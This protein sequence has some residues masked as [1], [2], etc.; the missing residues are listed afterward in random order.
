VSPEPVESKR[1]QSRSVEW[2]V[3]GGIVFVVL[4]IVAAYV[5]ERRR[6]PAARFPVIAQ[7]ADFALTNQLAQ[8]V[9][10]ADLRG[11]VWVADIIFTRCPGPCAT[12]TRRMAD[13]Q[14]ALP[15]NAPVKLVSLTTDPAHDTP[16]A[17][18]SYA[19]RFGADSN[20]WQFLTG[21]KADLVKL[22]VN[23]LKLTVLDKE[24]AKRTSPNDL[25]I[26]SSIFVVVDKQGRLRAVF[27]SLDN[28]LAE[29]EVATGASQAGS[30]WEKTGKPRLL[31]AVNALLVEPD[32]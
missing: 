2:A 22:A 6:V 15:A 20:R 32:R 17:L 14:A 18:A 30:T 29:E 10:L 21:P 31:E 12:M 11:Q 28:V 23:S 27:E 4:A 13:L 16:R 25:F 5:R 7:V 24:E 8:P 9:R 26:H 3:W 19:E 1:A